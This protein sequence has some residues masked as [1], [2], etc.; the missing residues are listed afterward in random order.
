[1]KLISNITGLE[2]E[3]EETIPYGNACQAAQYWNWGVYPIDMYATNENRFIFVYTKEQHKS[4][5]GRWN[6]QKQMK[7]G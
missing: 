6:S 1:M 3:S 5:I 2:Y 7:K 4:N